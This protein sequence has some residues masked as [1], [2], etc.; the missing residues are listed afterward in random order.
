[1]PRIP[2]T[3]LTF[4]LLVSTD[5]EVPVAD[6]LVRIW[7]RAFA[8]RP[9]RALRIFVGSAPSSATV[10]WMAQLMMRFHLTNSG[11]SAH[12]SRGNVHLVTGQMNDDRWPW[13]LR[14]LDVLITP[15]CTPS[16]PS[17]LPI[18]AALGVP[19]ISA[20]HAGTE[21]WCAAAGGWAIPLASTG[22]LEWPALAAACESATDSAERT[23]RS[24]R[25]KAAYA[26][27]PDAHAFGRAIMARIECVRTGDYANHFQART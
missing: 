19:L 9:D 26:E 13:A 16:V 6:A 20:R 15:L 25:A 7:E 23:E 18:A 24:E 2:E 21:D 17:V 11:G 5:D 22:R 4:G 27:L 14:S 1:M 12:L 8:A 3:T 10:E